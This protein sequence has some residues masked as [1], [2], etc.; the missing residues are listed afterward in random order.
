VRLLALVLVVAA[1]SKEGKDAARREPARS[2]AAVAV[3]VDAAPPPIKSQTYADLAA[4]LKAT[5]P[6]DARVVGFGEL[7]M[8]TDRKQVKSSL[9]WFTQDGLPAIADQLSDL[10]V[11]TWIVDPKCGQ[12]A[13]TATAKVEMTVRRPQETKSDIALLAEAARAAKVQPHAMKLT[14]EDYDKIAPASGDVAP[15]VLLGLTTKELRR[16]SGEAVTFRTK[17]AEKRPWI[18]VYGGAL[19]NDRFPA[20]GVEDWSY[21]AEVDGKTS[22]RFVEI[23]L[24]VPVLAEGDDTWKTQPWFELVTRADDKVHVWQRGERSFVLVLP[25]SKS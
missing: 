15:D 20:K 9:A 1:C 19:H 5:I 8:R 2:D 4:A 14:C 21:A 25:R 17:N 3:V 10:V 7:H 22:N 16:I 13:K 11:E 6:T 24:V 23:D 12:K 18:A